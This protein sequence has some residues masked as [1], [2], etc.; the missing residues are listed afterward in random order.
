MHQ[1]WFVVMDTQLHHHVL[2]VD[3]LHPR[4][5]SLHPRSLELFILPLWQ[6]MVDGVLQLVVL[7]VVPCGDG[8]SGSVSHI[9]IAR[10]S[11]C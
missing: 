5:V 8:L 11:E 4:D 10:C 3:H 2:V 9:I 7:S 1:Q 6:D